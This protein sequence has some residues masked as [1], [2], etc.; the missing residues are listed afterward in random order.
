MFSLGGWLD[1]DKPRKSKDYVKN[2]FSTLDHSLPR[3]R[4][5]RKSR[6]DSDPGQVIRSE[7]ECVLNDYACVRVTE[8]SAD[9]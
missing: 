9:I 1:K 8:R 2:G 3:S 5:S 6:P 7:G 4:A